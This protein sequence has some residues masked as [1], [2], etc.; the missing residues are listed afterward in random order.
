MICTYRM[1]H[2][3]DRIITNWLQVGMKIAELMVYATAYLV[4]CS[5]CYQQFADK[6]QLCMCSRIQMSCLR[7]FLNTW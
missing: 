1:L 6:T 2:K 5:Q 7:I 4:L 3:N